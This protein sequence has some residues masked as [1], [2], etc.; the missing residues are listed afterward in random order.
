[1]IDHSEAVGVLVE[2][3]EQ[4]ANIEGTRAELPRLRHVLTF[5]DLTARGARARLAAEQP[6]ALGERGAA[7]RRGGPLHLHLHVG[8]DRPAEGLHDP[9]PQLLRDGGRRRPDAA[10]VR[11]PRRPL[12]LYLPLAHN[13]GRLIHLQAPTSA[14]RSR[15]AATRCNVGEALAAVRPTVFPS[16]PR[17][18][19]KIHT[20]VLSRLDEAQRARRRKIGEWAI[21][22]G[23]G[24]SPAAGG[25]SRS[26]CWLALRHRSPTGS[27][28]RG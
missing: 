11:L 9:P 20:A 21:R 3:E 24:V 23:R 16:V 18:Y 5:A 26:R 14:T 27:S 17:V 2:D 19:E 13:Y 22:V 25:L 1:M 28:T 6:G 12:L 4:L 15:S 10:A 8:D 7:G